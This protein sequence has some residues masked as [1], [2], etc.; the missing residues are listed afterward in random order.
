MG[1]SVGIL[2]GHLNLTITD[3]MI[4][5]SIFFG[6]AG[7]L[8]IILFVQQIMLLVKLFKHGGV[9]LGI[10]GL[11]IPLFAFIWG[12]VKAGEF[13]MK[14]LMTWMTIILIICGLCYGAGSVAFF[15]SPEFQEGLKNAQQQSLNQGSSANDMQKRIEDSLK[16]GQR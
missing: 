15:S 12:W 11:C 2:P 16:Q 14:K 7:I 8:G 10:L 5:G 9:G 13:G 3:H 6:I 1:K 4:L